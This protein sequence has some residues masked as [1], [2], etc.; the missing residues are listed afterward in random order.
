MKTLLLCALLVCN[1]MAINAQDAADILSA[2]TDLKKAYTLAKPENKIILLLVVK[3]GCN[4][5][6][7]MV[8]ETLNSQSIQAELT[9]MVTVVVDINVK[10]PDAFKVTNTP[11]IFF[12]DAKREQSVWETVGFM[13]KGAFLIDIISAKERF[14][15]ES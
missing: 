5:C 9:D 4:W 11:A 10:L 1:L 14:N 8:R 2:Q 6:E 15:A 13:K 7:K 3:E 12:I